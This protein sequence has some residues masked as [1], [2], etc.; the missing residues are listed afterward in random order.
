MSSTYIA[1]YSKAHHPQMHVFSYA[2]FHS[3]GLDLDPMT[4]IYEYGLDILKMYPRTENEISTP[5]LSKVASTKV[6]DRRDA[7]KCITW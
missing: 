7:T 4:L 5:R 1:S 3:C 6:T 2:R